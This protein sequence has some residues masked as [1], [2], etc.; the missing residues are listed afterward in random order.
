VEEVCSDNR[1]G[2]VL[3]RSSS[4]DIGVGEVRRER[5]PWQ[6]GRLMARGVRRWQRGPK[7]RNEIAF[8]IQLAIALPNTDRHDLGN[9][10]S[11]WAPLCVNPKLTGDIKVMMH[12]D[13]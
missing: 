6:T 4:D 9:A 5:R 1:W 11:E 10:A 13:E 2:R 8:S 7:E 12:N 3:R